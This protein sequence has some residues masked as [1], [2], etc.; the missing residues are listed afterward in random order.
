MTIKGFTDS[1]KST[2]VAPDYATLQPVSPWRYGLE[3]AAAVFYRE[4]ATDAAEAGSTV[5]SV[6][7]TSHV[8]KKGD[9]ILWTSGSLSGLEFRVGKTETNAIILGEE[10]TQAP[11][12]ADTFTILRASSPRVDASGGLATSF[13]GDLGPGAAT[14]T[15]LKVVIATN[16]TTIPVTVSDGSGPLTVDGTVAATQSGS[17]TVSVAAADVTSLRA[18]RT[19]VTSVRHDY[20]AD[21]VTTGSWTQLV[22][23]TA[24]TVNE[25]HIFDSSGRTLE[26]GVGA[27]ASE[28]RRLLIPP[29]G[30][31]GPVSLQIASGSR[32]AV[33]AVSGTA[34]SGELSITFT[35]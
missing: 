1:K 34:S 4:V 12:A 11:A 23:S 19:Y 2:T 18:G 8:A 5:T 14:A 35:K 22:A 17:W 28:S 15:T 26:L 9:V 33:R 7:A 6:V 30:F 10:M 13:G 16:Q 3:V 32:I 21:D 27:A 29:G 25:L 31:S 24:D 20:A